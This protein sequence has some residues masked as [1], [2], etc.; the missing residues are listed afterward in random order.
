[1][2]NGDIWCDWDPAQAK[3]IACELK[4]RSCLAWLLMVPNP[5]QHPAGDFLLESNGLLHDEIA[6]AADAV[7]HTFAG[8]GVYQPE[9][10]EHTP[11]HRPAKLAPL[12]RQAMKNNRV[13]G[14]LHQSEWIDVGT[15]DR[16]A[17]LEVKI[18]SIHYEN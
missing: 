8:I 11:A 7:R 12:L 1:V 17:A 10:F 13:C 6:R 14:A 5:V 18:A 3:H 16:L 15:L 2:L 9:L 4:L